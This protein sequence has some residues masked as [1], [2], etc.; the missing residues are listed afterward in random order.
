[1]TSSAAAPSPAAP[2]CRNASGID[3][4]AAATMP[5]PYIQHDTSEYTSAAAAHAA[6]G[7]RASLV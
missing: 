7:R 6:T 4:K 5:M 2:R 3:P 1:M